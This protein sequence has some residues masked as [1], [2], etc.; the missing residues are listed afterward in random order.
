V[1]INGA[2]IMIIPSPFFEEFI[3]VGFGF[4]SAPAS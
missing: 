3:L 1:K 2:K 4:F